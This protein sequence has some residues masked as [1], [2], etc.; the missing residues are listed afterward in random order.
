MQNPISTKLLDNYYKQKMNQSHPTKGKRRS[1]ITWLINGI[2]ITFLLYS[3]A[4]N[5]GSEDIKALLHKQ[6]SLKTIYKEIASQ[7]EAVQNQIEKLD[8]S[9]HKKLT[10]VSSKKLGLTKFEHFFEVYGNVES[11]Q[12]ASVN[13]EMPGTIKEIRVE[14]GQ[15]VNKG[16][17]LA[18]LDK[19]IVQHNIDELNVAFELANTIFLKQEELWNQKIGSE[20][21]YLEAK[22]RKESLQ[23][24]LATLNATLQK[25]I[26]TAPFT[27]IIDEIFYKEGELG[28]IMLPL[29]RL[30]NINQVYIVAEVS[31]NYIS[32]I[33]EGTYVKV[34]I[35]S[36]NKSIEAQINRLG[37]SINPNNRTFKIYIDIRNQNE[38]L[39]PNLL[40]ILQIKDFEA[41][42]AI[43]VPSGII[44]QDALGKEFIYILNKE[45]NTLKAKKIMVVSGMSYNNETIILDG[46]SGEEEI[47]LK[48]ARN[49]KD[50]QKVRT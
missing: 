1:N 18:I 45:G 8:S 32:T 21:Q 3:C 5:K 31:E 28:N 19:E 12:N 35:T 27:G 20:L 29:L 41:D 39:K 2:L 38:E 22:S 6:D 46:L 14:V 15:T 48:G 4:H 34:E 47:V 43:V 26:I 42:S 36:L 23:Q 37:S 13:M 30:I 50:G 9:S 40:T 49:I 11:K 17:V 16:Q 10:I 33:K 44:Q 24:R 25:F 7:I